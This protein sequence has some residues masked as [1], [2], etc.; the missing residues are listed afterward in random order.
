MIWYYNSEETQLDYG[1]M[2]AATAAKVYYVIGIAVALYVC[3]LLLLLLCLLK[4][5]DVSGS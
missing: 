4:T 3:W 5:S 2:S 1:R